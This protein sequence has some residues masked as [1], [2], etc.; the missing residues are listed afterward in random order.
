MN[1][2]FLEQRGSTGGGRVRRRIQVITDHLQKH[3]PVRH[4]SWMD[5]FG[6]ITLHDRVFIETI[7][8][9]R[10][11]VNDIVCVCGVGNDGDEDQRADEP[12]PATPRETMRH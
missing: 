10:A 3:A 4:G 7:V 9:Q 2:S 11:E 8:P 1:C 6:T 5:G 12:P